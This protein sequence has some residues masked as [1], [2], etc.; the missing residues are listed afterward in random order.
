MNQETKEKHL[1]A[2]Q[3]LKTILSV[4]DKISLSGFCRDRGLSKNVP[5]ILTKN[6]LILNKGGMAKTASFHWNTIE[7]NL[8]MAEKVL[9]ES[10]RISFTSVRKSRQNTERVKTIQKTKQQEKEQT[11]KFKVNENPRMNKKI[12]SLFWG[13]LKIELNT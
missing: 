13:L 5:Q 1:K 6:K 3:D 10:N 9:Q 8:K 4:T 12:I 2:L 11:C 7:P